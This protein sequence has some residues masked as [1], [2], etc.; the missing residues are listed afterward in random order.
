[1]KKIDITKEQV[2]FIY[3]NNNRHINKTCEEL[4]V[5]KTWLNEFIIENNIPRKRNRDLTN[6]KFNKLLVI[7]KAEELVHGERAWICQ[8]ECGATRIKRTSELINYRYISCG[9]HIHRNG[10][11]HPNWKGCGEI[12]SAEYSRIRNSAAKRNMVFEPTIQD[13][14]ELFLKQ[15]RQCA[16]SNLFLTF[17]P[18]RSRLKDQTASLDRIDSSIGY[19]LDNIQWIHK[20]INWMKQDFNQEYFIKMCQIV[21]ESQPRLI[22]KRKIIERFNE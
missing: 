16:I 17:A 13:L 2:E 14:W 9:C 11:Q 15:E 22:S 18:T 7:K 6:E 21:T 12:A 4:G 5:G 19:T 10:A 20:D 3:F 8:C 1:M